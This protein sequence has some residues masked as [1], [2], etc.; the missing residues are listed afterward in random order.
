M[1]DAMIST[2]LGAI[3]PFRK[4]TQTVMWGQR[5]LTAGLKQEKIVYCGLDFERTLEM[6]KS[7]VGFFQKSI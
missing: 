5:E 4:G 2:S 3:G 1:L 6:I 7:N